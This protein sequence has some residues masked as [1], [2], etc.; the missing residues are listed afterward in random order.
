M[1][2]GLLAA[3]AVPIAIDKFVFA[4]NYPSAISN[5]AWASFLGSYIGAIIGGVV[6][7]TGIALTIRFTRGQNKSER[8]LQIRPYFD[9]AFEIEGIALTHGKDMGYIAWEYDREKDNNGNHGPVIDGLIVIKNVGIGT[10]LDCKMTYSIPDAGRNFSTI[11]FAAPNR[12]Q[13]VNAFQPGEEGHIR[14]YIRMN[15]EI[16]SKDRLVDYGDKKG[17][18]ADFLLKYPDID[19]VTF[20]EYK[21]ML[22]NE[23]VQELHFKIVTTASIK[24]DGSENGCYHSDIYFIKST[25]PKRVS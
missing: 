3:I 18:S 9:F 22:E 24:P 2:V 16:I 17:L 14:L 21:D 25:T 19:F 5:E 10:A 1:F 13:S 20:F 4:N 12:I 11:L 15:L 23:Y 7:L 8:E 6:S